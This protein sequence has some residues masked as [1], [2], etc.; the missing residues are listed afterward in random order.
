MRKLS[1]IILCIILLIALGLRVYKLTEIPPSL[2]WDEASLGYNA[3]AILNSGID[4]HGETYPT[5][6]FTAFGDYKPPGYI[7]ATAVS[8]AIFGSNEFSVRFPSS[9]SGVLMVLLTYFLVKLL[10]KSTHIALI[11]SFLL[12]ISPWSLQLSRAA[13]EAHLAAMYNLL[14]VLLF[15][16]AL[17]RKWIL[18]ISVISFVASFYTFNANRIIAPL[19]LG[20]LS[21]MYFKE[22]VSSKKW[23]ILSF[24]IG[25]CLLIPSFNY[26]ITRE[27]R[28]RFQEVSIFTSLDTVKKA[29]NRIE[30]D[31]NAW[32]AKILHNRRVYF[33]AD[34]LKHYVDNFKGSF[35][36]ISGD[37]NPRLSVQNSGEMYLFE[38]PFLIVGAFWLLKQKNKITLLLFGWLIIAP[39]P[40][41]TARET[42]HMLRIA[43]ILPIYQIITALGVV[44][45]WHFSRIYSFK[46][47]IIPCIFIALFALLNVAYYFHYYY[48]HYSSD[49]A[50]EWQYGY[51]QLVEKVKKL[52]GAYDRIEVTSQLGRPYIYFL[53]YNKVNPNDYVATRRAER[54][55][56]GLWNVYGFGNYDFQ[57]NLPKHNERILYAKIPGEFPTD[58]KILDKVIAPNGKT[59][60]LVGEY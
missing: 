48:A 18:P 43:S 22:I 42:P 11:S 29:N 32:W 37:Q 40:A 36:F 19:L 20:F 7:Y 54:D 35:L 38:L 14:G 8:M 1:I 27:S 10:Y 58:A 5:S 57:G 25:V 2:Y 23:I 50:G 60:F 59:V 13:F 33:A 3:Y 46:K 15:L 52:E 31:Q 41:A 6:R 30:R 17:K 39:I 51:K 56:Y 4:E 45:F 12:S 26:L 34:F 49:W 28:L 21:I 44:Y 47:R 9:A 55:W 16:L 53:F 24:I